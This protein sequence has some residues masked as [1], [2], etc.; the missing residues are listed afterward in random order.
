MCMYS[1]IMV[2]WLW[3]VT[4]V[5]YKFSII[6][7]FCNQY[8]RE[9]TQEDDCGP[10]Y[11]EVRCANNPGVKPV[12]SRTAR[13]ELAADNGLSEAVEVGKVPASRLQLKG[14]FIQKD[15]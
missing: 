4:W 5:L 2:E 13:I 7:S 6:L 14:D 15:L 10:Y 9:T 11:C 1:I 3:F 8:D 12:V